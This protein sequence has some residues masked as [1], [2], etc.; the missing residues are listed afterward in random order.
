VTKGYLFALLTAIFFGLQGTYGKVLSERVHPIVAAWGM[1]AFAA[2]FFGVL[3]LVEGVPP[4]DW[5]SFLWAT[6]VSGLANFAA[7]YLFFR[8]LEASP[9]SQTMPFTGFTPIFLI[10]VA[11]L[12]LQELPDAKGLAGI[13]LIISG[14][15]GI[16]LSSGS[17]LDPFKNLLKNKGTRLMLCVALIWSVSATVDKVGILAGSQAFYGSVLFS[18]LA[19]AYLPY[20]LWHRRRAMD[21][22]KEN[23]RGLVIMGIITGLMVIFQFTALQH[24]LVSY[25]IA[26]KRSGTLVSVLLGALLF[27]E[28]SPLKNLLSTA[29]MAAGV[30]LLLT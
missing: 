26:F 15:Y 13:L 24:M 25:V 3:L 14:A 20:M 11:Y 23:F 9:L 8:A 17:L 7:W 6:G 21:S 22:V 29:L 19:L 28:T 1:F 10:P 27:G 4:V 2:P 12:L 5:N 30:F 18:L 16:H